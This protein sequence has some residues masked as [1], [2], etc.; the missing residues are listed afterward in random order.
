MMTAM[1]NSSSGDPPPD[2][3]TLVRTAGERYAAS[4]GVPY[5][6]KN[7]P[8]HGGYPHITAQEWAQYDRDMA[9]R[10]ERRR[11]RARSHD[12]MASRRE[13]SRTARVARAAVTRAR[14]S[15]ERSPCDL[16]RRRGRPL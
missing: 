2:L 12:V 6:Q 1:P 14:P 7:H 8:E 16:H 4:L 9:A 11:A 13:P 15:R 5:D 3:Q 10:Q